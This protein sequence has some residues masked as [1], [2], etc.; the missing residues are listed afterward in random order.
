MS[1]A[2]LEEHRRDPVAVPRRG[3]I[4]ARCSCTAGCGRSPVEG[5]RR[6]SRVVEHDPPVDALD[7]EFPLR[8][9]TGRRL[10]SYNTGV[11]D[12]RL[13]L[14]AA[15]RRDARPLAGGRRAPRPRG[16]R[17]GA[18][19]RRAAGRSRRR[20]RIDPSLR[21]GL[22][23]MT[24]HF[25]DEVDVERAH[26]RR[27]RSQVGHRRV[28]GGGGP[29]REARAA[30][31]RRDR[32]MDRA[33]WICTST[34]SRPRTSAPRSTRCSARRPPAG[35]AAR[36]VGRDGNTRRGRPRGARAAAPAAAGAAGVQERVGWISE[37]GLNYVCA[38]LTVPPADAYGVA[39][40]YALLSHSS[41][42]RR[43]RPRLRRHRLPLQRG[44]AICRAARG[45]LRPR[46]E[47]SGPTARRR[48]T[49]ARASAC[50][51][52]RRPRWS[53]IAGGEPLERGAGAD[54][55]R[56]TC[57]RLLADGE[58]APSR[59][60]G[61]VRRRGDR[62]LRL[63]RRV[64]VVDPA[65]LDDYRAHG[66]YEALRARDRARPGGRASARSRTP[67]SSAAAAPRSRPGGSGRPSRA[68]RRGR[69]TSSATPTSPSPGTFKDRVLHGGRPVRA[70]RGDD[71]RRVR[72]RLRARLPLHARRVPA[73]APSAL[74][75]AIAASA[76]TRLPRRRTSWAR[77][78]RSTSRSGAAPAP[79]SAARRP[80]SSTRSRA[81]AASRATSRRSRSR[82]ASSASRPWSTTSR[83]WSTSSTRPP[84]RRPGV[85]RDRDRAVDR[86]E[87]LLRV[88]PRR[89]ARARTR[90]RSARRC[91]DVLELAGGVRGGRPLQ[92]V[93][94]GGAAGSSS[95][96]DELDMPLTFEG[97]R[98]AGT[99]LG[100]RRRHGVRRHGRPRPTP[101]ADRRVLPR[102]I[103]RPVRPV[104]RRDR[105]PG[106]GARPA[107][108]GRAARRRSSASS[109]CSRR[110]ASACATPRSAGS[111]RR[112]RAR[113]SRR[114]SG[115]ACSEERRATSA[116]EPGTALTIESRERS[117][118]R[119]RCAARARSSRALS[120]ATP[121]HAD[122]SLRPP[123]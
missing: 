68:S 43:G 109:R 42:A 47:P 52:G 116:F 28:Q 69:T 18:G 119:C 2:R 7:D 21:P 48:G 12:R 19:R 103:L 114:S 96:P 41:R 94:L 53:S 61:A 45:A 83:R 84:R 38:R 44:R 101:A 74:E 51:T 23:F 82:R 86:D 20:S 73:G 4:R 110:S 120:R 11:A 92:A 46:G 70:R 56:Q 89:A 5:R 30:E 104:P 80:R 117:E 57:W 100:L 81:T 102:R 62:S 16:R 107:P 91:G 14:A 33:G 77:A 31:L 1:Y 36:A 10:D 13:R 9:T 32:L 95:R 98:A 26:D 54:E 8:L 64:G 55:R 63:L 112:P 78:S 71:D 93:L 121:H 35:T 79:T 17:A 123:P 27:D 113:S 40:F 118:G 72:D 34:P 99:T 50:A 111:G 75:H 90:C 24:L 6:R 25:P 49:A 108:G 106:G 59:G 67:S 97:T 87:A 39:T 88:R 37:G 58:P 76:A 60:H 115:S 66:G 29:G 15:P 105:P 65:S 122:L 3:R 22:V 85:R